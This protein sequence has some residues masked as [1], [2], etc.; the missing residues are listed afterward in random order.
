MRIHP[1]YDAN[2]RIARFLITIYLSYHGYYVEWKKL[3]GSKKNEFIKKLNNCHIRENTD[4][5]EEYL[6]Y[7]YKFWKPYVIKKDIFEKY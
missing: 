2:G 1:F 6:E 3:D 4:L 5:Y 7:L